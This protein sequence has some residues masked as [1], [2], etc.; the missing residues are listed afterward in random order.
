MSTNSNFFIRRLHSLLGLIPI[1]I[2]LF[3]HL[4]INSTVLFGGYSSYELTIRGMKNIPLIIVAE[5]L[6][7]AIPI[8]FHGL[9]G[10]WI[11]YIAKNN[12]L[13]FTYYRN[14]AFYLQRITAVITLIFV[15]FHVYTLRLMQHEPDAIIN[16]FVAYLQNPMY[17]AL[18]IIGVLA[19]VYHF[20]NGLFTFLITW[21][22]TIGPRSQSFIT[23]LS[24][25]VFVI[26]SIWGVSV[27]TTIS[28]L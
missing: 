18:Y 17:F 19:A 21:G 9:Y 1:G 6:I 28:K 22:I 4:T 13:K 10:L 27:L 24:V 3:V 20:A 26:M 25:I 2:F 16:T 7:I 23:K 8:I 12:V 15:L 5:L 11:V 14:W